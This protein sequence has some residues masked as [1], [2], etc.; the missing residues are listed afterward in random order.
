MRPGDR[1]PPQRQFARRHRIAASTATRVYS[2]LTR[3][4]LV[5][6][7]VGRGTFVRATKPLPEPALAEPSSAPVDLE[8]NFSVLPELPALLGNG[9]QRL[10]R[11]DMLARA[12]A[13]PTS[14]SSAPARAAVAE[15]LSGPHWTVSPDS[16]LLAG[17]GRQAIAA[18]IA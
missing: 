2:E 18:A 9:L 16:V 15:F 12:M 5:V 4:G 7:E 1:L 11:P 14:A 13:P 3:R 10:S 17:S 8:L 6:G